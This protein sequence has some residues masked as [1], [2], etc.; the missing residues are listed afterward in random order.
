M[1][2]WPKKKR[3]KKDNYDLTRRFEAETILTFNQKTHN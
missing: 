1:C 2:I 3:K